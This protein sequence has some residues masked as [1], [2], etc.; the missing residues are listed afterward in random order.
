MT[1]PLPRPL[2]VA[3]LATQLAALAGAQPAAPVL[4]G[5]DPLLARLAAR[6]PPT[7][8]KNR[9]RF[10]GQTGPVDGFGAGE[11]YPQVWLRD[12]ATLVPL[13][14]W[15][16]P[17]ATLTSWLEEHLAAQNPDGSLNDWIAAGP[18]EAFREWAP[19]VRALAAPA[20]VTLSADTNTTE[21]DQESSAVLA[22]HEVF[23][24]TGDVAW[25]FEPV[26]G[27][28]L[29]KRLDRALR[30]VLERRFD[31]R[32]GLI[33]NALTADWG[34]VSPAYP[35][36][37]AI[38]LDERTPRAVG[39]YTNALLVRAARALAVL[40]S[41]A[42]DGISAAFWWQKADELGAAVQGLLWQETRGFYRMHLVTT[43]ALAPG[44]PE[45]ADVFPL[46]GNAVALLAG[47]GDER[48]VARVLAAA[49]ERRLRNRLAT[50]AGTLLPPLPRGAFQH[51]VLRE[52]W[53]YQNGGEWDW[54]A[55]RLLTAAFQRG[56]AAWA[57]RQLQAV[58]AA[59]ERAGGLYE[60][61][62][63]DG[64][65]RGSASY[66]GSAGA[67][68]EALVAG[69][70]GVTLTGGRLDLA[71]RLGDEAGALELRPPDGRP[72]VRYDYRFERA[73]GRA[74]LSLDSDAPVPGT[75]ALRLPAG[76]RPVSLERDGQPL[77]FE[78]RRV[79][80]DLYAVAATGW[81]R[82]RFELVASRAP[83]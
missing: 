33:E 64:R 35:D 73:G 55:G 39:L 29:L 26:A 16:C 3:L 63:R 59:V 60:W 40:H 24:A 2:L 51:P 71:V 77:A 79:G 25:L 23:A 20:G 48:Q 43:P 62:S 27:Q 21:A 10:T 68:G 1:G 78:E 46:G 34:D 36:Q 6:L 50:I 37:R 83:R 47:L 57:R 9:K 81:G 70:Y 5:G 44:F 74:V 52:E 61:R 45:T 13:S 30:F 4:R 67:L 38:Y 41:H 42:G 28:P 66:A 11:A 19:R 72:G 7:L 75:L 18:P 58:A 32:R 82:R 15:L 12:S 54:F 80:E 8:E 53:Q 76:W 65:G 14:R 69:L 31:A 17:R 56:H 22:A 49:E